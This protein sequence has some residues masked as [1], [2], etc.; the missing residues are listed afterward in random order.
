MLTVDPHPSVDENKSLGGGLPAWSWWCWGS[1][2]GGVDGSADGSADG[3]DGWLKFV[4]REL[5][6]ETSL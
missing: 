4:F 6:F 5:M 3:F 1:R 2:W